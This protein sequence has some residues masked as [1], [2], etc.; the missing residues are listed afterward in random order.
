MPY[1]EGYVGYKASVRQILEFYNRYKTKVP[2]LEETIAFPA[3]FLKRFFPQRGLVA[4]G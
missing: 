4:N 3:S 2:H 1:R